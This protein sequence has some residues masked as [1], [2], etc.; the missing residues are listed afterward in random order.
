MESQDNG[1]RKTTVCGSVKHNLALVIVE[2]TAFF[3]WEFIG[4]LCITC[5]RNYIICVSYKFTILKKQRATRCYMNLLLASSCSKLCHTYYICKDKSLGARLM[6]LKVH[7][8]PFPTLLAYTSWQ[9]LSNG[10]P[11]LW[12]IFLYHLNNDVIFLKRWKKQLIWA[13]KDF[14]AP[15]NVYTINLKTKISNRGTY[16]FGPWPFDQLRI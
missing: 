3:N 15:A 14:Q 12:T 16:F 4:E 7:V 5:I 11:F 6:K 10:W 9:S 13:Y 8:I 2:I 1:K